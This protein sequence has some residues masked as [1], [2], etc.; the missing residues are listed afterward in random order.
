MCNVNNRDRIV[1][2]RW[3]ICMRSILSWLKGKRKVNCSYEGH[4]GHEGY[5][6]Y[7]G[8]DRYTEKERVVKDIGKAYKLGYPNIVSVRAKPN[9]LTRGVILLRE[10]RITLYGGEKD[11]VP[12][13]LTLTGLKGIYNYDSKT[14]YLYSVGENLIIRIEKGRIKGRWHPN[15]NL[16]LWKNF[17][18]YTKNMC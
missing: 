15:E 5:E 10:D 7:G 2:K 13:D 17:V 9:A 8:N 18:K 6:G 1:G 3:H 11:F 4:E 14:T 16:A 12:L